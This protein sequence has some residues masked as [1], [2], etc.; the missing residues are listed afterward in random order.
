[1]VSAIQI[2]EVWYPLSRVAPPF[3]VILRAY[4]RTGQLDERDWFYV[5]LSDTL[6]AYGR[7]SFIMVGDNTI[8]AAN[9]DV[10]RFI[11][12]EALEVQALWM[13]LKYQIG[14]Y[15]VYDR[16]AH[17]N[18]WLTRDTRP[19]LV[20]ALKHRQPE[21]KVIR[22]RNLAHWALVFGILGP[23]I[24]ILAYSRVRLFMT[25]EH[26][27]TP[28]LKDSLEGRF[29]GDAGDKVGQAYW[30]YIKQILTNY[31]DNERVSVD[32]N[33]SNNPVLEE[34]AVEVDLPYANMGG[35]T[36]LALQ[37]IVGIY[38]ARGPTNAEVMQRLLRLAQ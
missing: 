6:A 5:L 11:Q 20:K 29:V 19:I 35:L 31:L 3:V 30:G 7:Q 23:D 21:I 33:L 14:F 32:D 2:Y 16:S 36:R 17:T 4:Y 27:F 28:H 37:E 18:S 26:E 10:S 15:L 25:Y 1:M 9:L 12:Q 13:L 24:D 34:V 22:E 38:A 8:N